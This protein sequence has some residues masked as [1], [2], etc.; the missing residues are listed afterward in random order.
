[1]GEEEVLPGRM[2]GPRNV[3]LLRTG[4]VDMVDKR[5]SVSPE[6]AALASRSATVYGRTVSTSL[7]GATCV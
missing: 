6:K 5:N 1:M 7:A 4:E 2:A 3:R